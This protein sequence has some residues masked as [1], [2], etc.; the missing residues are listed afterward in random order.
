MKNNAP[1]RPPTKN[2]PPVDW[3]NV[4][5]LPWMFDDFTRPLYNRHMQHDELW[6]E[7]LTNGEA[8]TDAGYP[9]SAF[10]NFARVCGGAHVWVWRKP[11]DVIEVLLQ[12]R[13]VDKPTWGGYWD[14][15]AAGHINKGETV[16]AAATREAKEEIN[17][18][19]NPDNLYLCF[20]RRLL[21]EKYSFEELQSIFLYRE[22]GGIDFAFNDGETEDLKWVTLDQL[23]AAIADETVS[24]KIVPRGQLYFEPLFQY[25]EHLASKET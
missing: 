15:S 18:D 14:I 24:E 7:F 22:E 25:L 6:Q 8:K 4:L 10:E 20:S 3:K 16:L 21:N 12:K 17:L 1:I 9:R 2:E 23:K 13:A 5:V 11:A 19:I